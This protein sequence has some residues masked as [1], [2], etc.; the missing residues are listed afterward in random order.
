MCIRD[1]EEGARREAAPLLGVG[2]QRRQEEAA[3][4]P[5]HPDEAADGADVVGEVLGDV[6]VDGGL[7]DA[8]GA[9]EQK[10]LSLIH[11]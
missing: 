6:L 8:H 3:Q 4:A 9:A 10:D 7:A 1:S 5:E 11:I 2:E